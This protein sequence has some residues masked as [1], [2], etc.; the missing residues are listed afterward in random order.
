MGPK[1]EEIL[2]PRKLFYKKKT[3]KKR[4]DEDFTKRVKEDIRSYFVPPERT[5]PK[6]TMPRGD[7]GLF[8]QNP[9]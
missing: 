2:K 4:K 1:K 3:K 7:D 9:A 6:L 5:K 8:Q